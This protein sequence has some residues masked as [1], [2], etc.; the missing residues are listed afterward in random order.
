MIPSRRNPDQKPRAFPK[1]IIALALALPPLGAA[2]DALLR[3]VRKH[4]T[5]AQRAMRPPERAIVDPARKR[6][7]PLIG[8]ATAT[9]AYQE[10]E[11]GDR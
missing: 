8:K 5:A 9:Q 7:L 4:P 6:E 2:G 11:T 3:A 1:A 10:R